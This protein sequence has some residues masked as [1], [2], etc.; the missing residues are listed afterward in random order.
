[1]NPKLIYDVGMHNGDDTAYYLNRGYNVVAVEADPDLAEDGRKRFASEIAA[2]RLHI[3]NCAI[4][5]E[6]GEA[7]F[8]ICESKRIWNSF[9]RASASREGRTCR[10]VK[11][12]TRPLHDLLAE[13][14]VPY[15]LKLDIE[16]VDP[17]AARDLPTN[18]LPSYVSME[19]GSV[20]DFF[21]LRGKGYGQFKCIQQGCFQQ[22]RSPH[23][24][25]RTA[26]QA[27]VVRFKSH[28]FA[29]QLRRRYQRLLNTQTATNTSGGW[30]FD[31]G[32]SGPFGEDTPGSWMSFEEVLHAWLSVQI[33][34]QLGYRVKPPGDSQWFDL[35][36]RIVEHPQSY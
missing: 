33:G 26:L 13:H 6:A 17:V 3:E 12:P 21:L 20:E 1:M 8:F 2:G 9:D 7:D 15:Y 16:G 31:P 11:V 19:I 32:S 10:A 5:E 28:P 36:A 24:S 4:S 35:H 18:D 30:V 23:L 14:G 29:N 34:H 27:A 25:V 22:V